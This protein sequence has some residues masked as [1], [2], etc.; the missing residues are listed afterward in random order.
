MVSGTARGP[1]DKQGK[2]GPTRERQPLTPR[3][4]CKRCELN[5]GRSRDALGHPLDTGIKQHD[6][7]QAM[8]L[9]IKW[10][11]VERIRVQGKTQFVMISV[12]TP[13]TIMGYLLH[14]SGD[15]LDFQTIPGEDMTSRRLFLTSKDIITRRTRLYQNYYT[16]EWSETQ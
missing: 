4:S 14:K 8:V 1:T 3:K 13:D 15:N 7:R 12:E 5:R 11:H 6:E 9:P 16:G 10:N 2:S